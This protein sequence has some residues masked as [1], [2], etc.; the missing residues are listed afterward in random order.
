MVSVVA[1]KK[2]GPKPDPSRIRDAVTA[3]RSSAAWKEYVERLAEFDRA[4]SVADLLDR[5]I[6]IYARERGFDEA[7][8]KR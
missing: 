8:P 1:K 4:P 7:P 2:A 6:V 5:S 3:V